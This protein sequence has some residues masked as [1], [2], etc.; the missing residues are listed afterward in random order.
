[1]LNVP[2]EEAQGAAGDGVVPFSVRFSA[3]GLK[4]ILN[5]LSPTYRLGTIA[6]P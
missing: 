3:F 1:M 6:H 4:G 5:V 2:I